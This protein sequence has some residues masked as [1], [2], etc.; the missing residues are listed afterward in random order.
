MGTVS[1]KNIDFTKDSIYKN[2]IIFAIPIILGELFQN[3][4]H[5]TDSLVLGNFVG[6]SALAAVSVNGSLTNLLVGFCSG[7][8]VGST[9]TVAKAFGA[10]DNKLIEESVCYNYT[11]GVIVGFSLSIIGYI[12]APTLVSI[13]NTSEEIYDQA[14]SYLR[15]Y[16]SGLMFTVTYNNTAGILRGLGDMRTP[17]KVLLVSCSLNIIL[18]LL[19]CAVFGWAIEGVAIAT[20]ISQI[21][22][23]LISYYVIRYNF[24][25]RCIN[26]KDTINYGKNIIKETL[27][28]GVSAGIQS[29]L[30]SF[31][32]LFVWR[33]INRFDTAVVAGVGVA[34][35]IEKFVSFPNNAFGSAIT[36]FTSQNLGAKTNERI[37]KGIRACIILSIGSVITLALLILPFATPLASLFNRNNDVINAAVSMIFVLVPFYFLNSIRQ[38]QMG[39]LRAYHKST[40][41]MVLTLS[42]MVGVRQLYLAIAMSINSVPKTVFIGY[43]VGWFAAFLFV[44]T[45]YFIYRRKIIKIS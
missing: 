1:N 12:L 44:G 24:N 15:I 25:F 27:D 35:K 40:I 16:I 3:L 18:D 30:I 28:V 29:S 9:V 23:V 42:G 32:N 5:S 19:F 38:I 20:V 43:P 34:Q 17:F 14:L 11:F 31:S 37:P 7:L 36:T 41:T 4:Y 26:F 8:S 2:I 6:D 13:A 33:Y 45:Y 39:V 21:V 10:K 22:S